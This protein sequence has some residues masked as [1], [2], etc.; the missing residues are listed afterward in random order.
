M[1]ITI[2]HLHCKVSLLFNACNLNAFQPWQ[3]A[4]RRRCR[5]LNYSLE[6]C[7]GKMG[8]SRSLNSIYKSKLGASHAI[9]ILSVNMILINLTWGVKGKCWLSLLQYIVVLNPMKV[10]SSTFTYQVCLKFKINRKY[11]IL[12]SDLIYLLFQHIWRQSAYFK[13][14]S[15]CAACK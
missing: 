1:T 6:L 12:D 7:S 3:I 11:I 2:K 14:R 8:C 4:Q 13:A 10:H 9:Y 5:F 15:A